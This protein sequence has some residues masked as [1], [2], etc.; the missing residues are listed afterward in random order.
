MQAEPPQSAGL[1]RQTDPPA[2]VPGDL[3]PAREVPPEFFFFERHSVDAAFTQSG[4][5]SDEGARPPRHVLVRGDE[6]PLDLLSR[7]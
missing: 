5:E 1:D 6:D 7:G 2:P 3:P 4:A